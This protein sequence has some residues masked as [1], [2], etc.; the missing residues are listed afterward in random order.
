MEN[1]NLSKLMQNACTIS[2]GRF[3]N[4]S[5]NKNCFDS[6]NKLP[7][8]ETTILNNKFNFF[9]TNK[10]CFNS[11]NKSCK[12]NNYSNK[13]IIKPKDN[14]P[15]FYYNND[16]TKPIRAGG[17]LFYRIGL[18]NIVEFLLIENEYDKCFEDIGGKTDI[19]DKTNIDTICR[20]VDE[21]TNKKISYDKM[22]EMINNNDN[23]NIYVESSKYLLYIIKSDDEIQNLSE[24]DFG[25][26]ELHTGYKRKIQWVS[27]NDYLKKTLNPRLMNY[28][29]KK[30]I[31]KI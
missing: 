27:K 23:D 7:K 20:E 5:I 8:Q 12:S 9:K 25:D 16:L 2:K 3:N 11:L 15:T 29:I 14:R 6:L 10:D 22:K 1:S 30:F 31:E 21:E 13:L 4:L 24:T 17:V 18:N 28:S 26:I 19:C